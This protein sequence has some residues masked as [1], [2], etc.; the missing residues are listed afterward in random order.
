[1][2]DI[3]TAHECQEFHQSMVAMQSEPIHSLM[4]VDR[5]HLY[6]R[7]VGCAVTGVADEK[8]AELKA[9]LSLPQLRTA[10]RA[11]S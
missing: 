3:M 5:C 2:R 9:P 8:R 7:E 4:Y 10:K 1:M 6:L 11:K